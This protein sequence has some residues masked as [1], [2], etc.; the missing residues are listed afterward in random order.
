MRKKILITIPRIPYPL[1]SGGR[2]AIYEV[3]NTLSK[4]YILTIIIIDDNKSNIVYINEIK[5]FS[6]NV[7]FLTKHRF[8]FILNSLWGLLFGLPLQVGYFYFREYQQIINNLSKTHD[9]FYSFMIR[10]SLYGLNLKLKKGHYA[11]DSMYLNYKKSID[12]SKS[13]LWKF[14]YNIEIPLLYN[15]EKKHVK[16]YNITSFVNS[17]EAIFWERFGNVLTL[18]HGVEDNLLT[19]NKYDEKYSNSV[20]FIGRMDYQPN[21]D[22]VLWF[23]NNVLPLLSKDIKFKVIGGFPTNEIINLQK[24]N[25]QIEILG[26]VED[27]KIILRSSICSVAPMRTGGGLQTKVL[28][29]MAVGSLVILSS[30][31]AEAIENAENRYNLF[32]EDYPINISKLIHDIRNKPSEFYQ[33]RENAKTLIEKNYILSV[34]NKKLINMIESQIN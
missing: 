16:K 3:L 9:Y 4:Y 17:Q 34:V 33:I 14:I 13:L 29:S 1:N 27:P 20:T 25:S 12:E 24:H 10:T 21:I 19:Y 31:A 15:I 18:S 22:A 7:Y 23:C 28:T 2:I 26:F 32:I 5:K 6:D 8:R 30:V 11:I